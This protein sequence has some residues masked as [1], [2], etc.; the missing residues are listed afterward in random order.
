MKIVIINWRS[1]HDP[2]EGGAERATFEFAK[3]WVADYGSDVIWISPRYENS[4]DQE[5]V[6]GVRFVYLGRPL[7][8]KLSSLLVS[9]PLFY[10]SVVIYYLK[11]LKGKIDVVIDQVHGLPYMTPLYVSEKKIIYIHEV[12]GS[13]WNIMYPIPI[14]TIG[15]ILERI[16]FLPYKLKNIKFIANSPST[17]NDLISKLFINQKNICVVPYGVT[18]PSNES[19]SEKNKKFTVVFLNRVVKMKGIERGLKAFQKVVNQIPDAELHVIGRGEQS[20]IDY[21]KIMCKEL[22]IENNVMFLGFIDGEEKF[23]LLSSAHVLMNPSHLEGWG[24][25][26]I[27]ANRMGTPVVAFRV[28]GCVDSVVDN[29]SGFLCD[30]D[31]I[32]SMSDN[33][34]KA[35]NDV[36]L[37]KSAISY[38]NKFDWD[39]Q[40]QSFFSEL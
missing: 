3:R 26:N 39:L 7:N 20:Y 22:K 30:D 13:I 25:V 10:I 21:L 31:D 40:A 33:I 1:I 38:S 34:I 23:K 37:R 5:V 36:Q 16:F 6:D 11:S 35:G 32:D 2:L 15:R 18:A 19:V 24:L 4:P 8:R 9:F 17:F 27:E 29:I 14:S 28:R 12:A